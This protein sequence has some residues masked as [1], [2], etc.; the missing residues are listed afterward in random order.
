MRTATDYLSARNMPAVV[1]ANIVLS[2]RQIDL[3][4]AL[5]PGVLVVELKQLNAPIRGHKNGY[6]QIRLAS[7]AWKNA[8]NA[9][10]QTLREALA[11]RDAMSAF[12]GVDVPYPNAALVLVPALLAGSSLPESDFK[13]SIASLSDLPQLIDETKRRGW[14]LE[15]WRRFATHL[16]VT[17]VDSVESAVSEKLLEAKRLLGNYERIFV[18]TYGPMTSGYVVVRGICQGEEMSSDA[19][20]DGGAIDRNI[21]LTGPSGCSKSLLSH[22]MALKA[23]AHNEI[24]I[25]VPAKDF[26]G[27]L[28]DVVDREASLLGARSGADLITAARLIG[29]RLLL[30]VDGYNECTP[31]ERTRLTRSIVAAIRRYGARAIVSSQIALERDDLLLMQT[32]AIKPPDTGTKR[33]IAQ[34]AAGALSIQPLTDLLASVGSCLEARMIGELGADLPTDTSKF[35]LFDAFVR[36]LLGAAASDGIRTLTRV[37]AK[38]T[39]RVSFGLSIRELDRVA[40]QEAVSG[41]LLNTLR[42]TH[43]LLIRGGRVSFSHEMFFNLFAAEATVRLSRDDPDALVTALRIPQSGEIKAFV[44]GAIDDDGFRRRVLDRITDVSA[45]RACLEGQCGADA[46][47]WANEKCDDVLVRVAAEIDTVRF[48]GEPDQ[49]WHMEAE[50]GTLQLWSDQD[51]EVLKSIPYELLAGHRLDQILTLARKMDA[52]MRE[53]IDRLSVV[54][55]RRTRS[56]RN[57][58]YAAS[59]AGF[60]RRETGLSKLFGPIMS[61][62]LTTALNSRGHA[63]SL[64]DCSQTS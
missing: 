27:S 33:A 43:L 26:D 13:V 40:D 30:V 20:I 37:A 59:F 10:E 52:R 15:T 34:A 18:E 55:P 2:H 19:L 49:L 6:W 16:H 44:L 48:K 28:R 24:P 32:Y 25:I 46:Q 58:L 1:L 11:L 39:E 12:E 64:D 60:G 47:R 54:I 61:G 62:G 29:R 7:G 63:M 42:Q 23:F 4:I 51:E 35:G 14:P 17:Q 8:P 21:L 22:R 56:L 5:D 9:Y 45:I 38:M 3:V 31:S 36:H 53:E 41:A 57:G 50:P